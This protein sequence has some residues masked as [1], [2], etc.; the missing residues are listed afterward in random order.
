MS[1]RPARPAAMTA[2]AF[3]AAALLAGC[4]SGPPPRAETPASPGAAR[5]DE[6]TSPER[7]AK[8]DPTTARTFGWLGIAVG[9]EAAVVA[10]V[11]SV[12]MLDDK[13]TRDSGC[14]AQKICSSAGLNANTQLGATAAWNAGAFVLAAA[15]LGVG[16]FL[17]VT[18]PIHRQ[19][20]VSVSPAGFDLEA[21]F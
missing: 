12:I 4:A 18:H 3:L 13:S 9:A 8:S 1:D 11:T 10:T 5:T 7:E 19:A 14:S 16:T 21:K 6:D 15:G 17:L 2:A 20:T